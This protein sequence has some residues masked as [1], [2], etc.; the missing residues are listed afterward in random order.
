MDKALDIILGKSLARISLND[1]INNV[2]KNISGLYTIEITDGT[3]T[4]DKWI[5]NDWI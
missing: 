1:N 2:I 4:L 3:A 5:D